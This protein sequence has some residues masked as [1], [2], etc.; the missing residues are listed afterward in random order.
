VWPGQTGGSRAP[1]LARLKRTFWR[2][3]AHNS[4]I[5]AV[6]ELYT[7][8]SCGAEEEAVSGPN[9]KGQRSGAQSTRVEARPGEG[10]QLTLID[11][12]SASMVSFN[13]STVPRMRV[14]TTV[15]SER[16]EWVSVQAVGSEINSAGED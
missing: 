15:E 4:T 7:F 16:W 9:L 3:V 1:A 11:W 8:V 10:Q 14:I 5:S 2:Y 13:F 12:L 6:P